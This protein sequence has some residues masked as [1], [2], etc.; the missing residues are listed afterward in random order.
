VVTAAILSP[1]GALR[2]GQL[3]IHGL[4]ACCIVGLLFPALFAIRTAIPVLLLTPLVGA[5]CGRWQ[6]LSSWPSYK[7]VD[8]L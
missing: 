3:S 6:T 4:T 7:H 2:L 8:R 1:Q 5:Q